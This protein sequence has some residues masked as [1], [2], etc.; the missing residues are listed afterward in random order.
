[1][2]TELELVYLWLKSDKL[3]PN[4]SKIFYIFF[5]NRS[6][7]DNFSLLQLKGEISNQVSTIKF[8]GIRTNENINKKQ[9]INDI[10]LK[11]SKVCG[12][13]YKIKYSPTIKA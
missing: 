7:Q 2:Q 11:V 4:V 9:H 10:T 12:I 5:Q 8:L 13:L 3:K 6:I 1:M